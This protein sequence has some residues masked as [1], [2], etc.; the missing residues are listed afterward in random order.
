LRQRFSSGDRAGI[1]FVAWN[2]PG[3]PFG[4]Q[5]D[6]DAIPNSLANG[7]SCANAIPH[8][9]AKA[10]ADP[11]AHRDS[12]RNAISHSHADFHAIADRDA[13]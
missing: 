4:A 7:H 2:D 9:D 8:R 1:E 3:S 10:Y 5:L 12:D 11:K 6:R 13:G